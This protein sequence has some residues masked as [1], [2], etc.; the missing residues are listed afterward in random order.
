MSPPLAERAEGQGLLPSVGRRRE[1]E[2]IF[3]KPVAAT[4]TRRAESALRSAVQEA[5]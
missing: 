5:L 2:T 3:Q 1:R 4:R